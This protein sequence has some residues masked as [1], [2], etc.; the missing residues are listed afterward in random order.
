VTRNE[1]ELVVTR[2][3]NQDKPKPSSFSV[4]TGLEPTPVGVGDRLDAHIMTQSI[5]IARVQRDSARVDS[6]SAHFE[7]PFSVPSTSVEMLGRDPWLTVMAHLPKVD[8]ARLLYA[9]II[10]RATDIIVSVLLLIVLSPILLIAMIAIRLDSPGNAIFVQDRVGRNGRIFR[11]YKLRTMSASSGGKV[12]WMVDADG[13]KRHKV[14]NDPRVTR[15]GKWLRAT[16][17]DELPQLV[18][19]IKG[20]MSLIG[21]RPELV[22][23]VRN[24]EDWQ[25]QRHI[26]RPGLTG[27]WQVSGRSDKP[28]HENTEL[29]LY[30]VR[31]QSFKL[32]AL[33]ALKT[34]RVVIKGL[35]A[36]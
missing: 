11:L 32:D 25:H 3:F 20:D 35:G 1:P 34:I 27:W 16:S 9:T 29:D 6:G 15:V 19:I 31:G 17:V 5:E 18:N 30:Y 2:Q 8:V 22:E 33:I 26:V 21:P 4:S 10:K 36:F 7:Y 28:M 13:K 14:R 23:I 12:A 24:Y